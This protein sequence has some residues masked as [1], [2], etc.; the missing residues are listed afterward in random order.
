MNANFYFLMVALLLLGTACES[1]NSESRSG[2]DQLSETQISAS[3]EQY[4]DQINTYSENPVL[5]EE[6]ISKSVHSFLPEAAK[7]ITD[8]EKDLLALHTKAQEILLSVKGTPAE[9]TVGKIVGLRMLTWVIPN[10]S[11]VSEEMKLDYINVLNRNMSNEFLVIAQTLESSKGDPFRVK[12]EAAVA[13]S[14]LKA[15]E[16]VHSEEIEELEKVVAQNN[17]ISLASEAQGYLEEEKSNWPPR[18]DNM[19]R[20][21]KSVLDVT[22]VQSLLEQLVM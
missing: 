19:S 3:L 1:Y 13:L 9:S 17:N 10:S 18:I 12:Q 14:N 4:Y 5:A 16:I 20:G 2:T 7:F 8:E 15:L 11:D 6:L 22:I 21:G